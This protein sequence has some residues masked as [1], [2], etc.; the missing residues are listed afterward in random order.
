A[1]LSKLKQQNKVNLKGLVLDLRNNPG[2]VLNAAVS[3]S[4]VF[5]TNGLIVYT[6]GRVADAQL[7]FNATGN[8]LLGGA[9]MV[10]LVNGG[11]AS[12]SELSRVRYRTTSAP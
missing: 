1:A 8:D 5:L 2:G 9:P 3:V 4:D 11:S 10:V 7:K 6:Q 12:A